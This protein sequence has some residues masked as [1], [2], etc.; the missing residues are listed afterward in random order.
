MLR[1]QRNDAIARKSINFLAFVFHV[2][3]RN[4]EWITLAYLHPVHSICFSNVEN[5]F[6]IELNCRANPK[7]FIFQKHI[8]IL[9]NF[10][11]RFVSHEI[12]SWH[13]KASEGIGFDEKIVALVNALR[14][15][16]VNR[17]VAGT[18]CLMGNFS[19]PNQSNHHPKHLIF[20]S[21]F[22]LKFT[23]YTRT[24]YEISLD[25]TQYLEFYWKRLSY[26]QCSTFFALI[27][28]RRNKFMFVTMK[29][30]GLHFFFRP[31]LLFLHT[32]TE[33][34]KNEELKLNNQIFFVCISTDKRRGKSTNSKRNWRVICQC[35]VARAYRKSHHSSRLVG[36]LGWCKA[37]FNFA[38]L[39]ILAVVMRP[40]SL[41]NTCV[42]VCL[43]EGH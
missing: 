2:Y 15:L 36:W 11:F 24:D 29:S 25:D 6:K 30:S 43:C 26:N 12:K 21:E 1:I 13:G 7:A 8:L 4:N 35:E 38:L 18:K 23:D 40:Q 37:A 41:C 34:K 32:H 17:D 27:P 16:R 22:P 14:V 5:F 20:I 28:C 33:R 3:G 31:L 9:A 39:R 10:M 42:F 19:P